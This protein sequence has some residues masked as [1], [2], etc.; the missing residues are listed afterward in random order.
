MPAIAVP[1][2]PTGVQ[3][4]LRYPTPSPALAQCNGTV[5]PVYGFQLVDNMITLRGGACEYFTVNAVAHLNA[6]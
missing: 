6:T 3:T 1:L 4:P 2:T 5:R